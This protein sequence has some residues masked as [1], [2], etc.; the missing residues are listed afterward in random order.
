M[1]AFAA[2]VLAWART[3]GRTGLPWQQDRDPYRVW[4]AE[5]MLQQ[6]QVATVVPYFERFVAAFPSV[7]ALA[8]ADLDRV[9]EHWQG[10]G[11]YARARN[12]H[13]AARRIRDDHAGAFPRAFADVAALPGIGR[14]TA[15]AILATAFD[16]RHP[17]LDGNCKRVYARHAGI[18]GDPKSSA[19]LAALWAVAEERTPADDARAYTQAIMDL[20]SM[21]CT[22]ARPACDRCPVSTDCVA[23]VSARIDAF[24]GRAAKRPRPVRDAVF[25]IVRDA[26]G[27][28]LLEKRPATGVWGGLWCLPWLEAA[29]AATAY[30]AAHGATEVRRLDLV[31]HAFTH[32]ELRIAPV[33]YRAAR[34][35]AD[36]PTAA[37][38]TRDGWPRLALPTPVR[39]VLDALESAA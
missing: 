39:R 29:D 26:D 33:E 16:E 3:H 13:A 19:T 12:L 25:A 38:V 8:D 34:A 32:F 18:G 22:R 9:L 28:V 24:P 1:T 31:Q 2:R 20:G 27:A 17:I 14:S 37:W 30:A 10:L 35:A 5:V 4:V 36:T 7:I 11:Y 21:V 15:G 23:R 6:T